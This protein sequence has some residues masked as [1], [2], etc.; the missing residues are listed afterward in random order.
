M[1]PRSTRRHV[2]VIRSYSVIVPSLQINSQ[3]TSHR[4]VIPVPSLFRHCKYTQHTGHCQKFILRHRYTHTS[5]SGHTGSVIVSSLQIYTT[6]RSL[7]KVHTPSSV[8]TH[9][10]RSYRLRHCFVTANIDNTHV[11]VKSLY[12]VISMS[13][14]YTATHT[15]SSGRTGSVGLSIAAKIGQH[16]PHS[17]VIV[18]SLQI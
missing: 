7:S 9:I 11:T 8:H 3:H 10:V 5:S 16:M 4:Q 14:H 18:S 17:Q 2:I 1:C 6:H 15:S 13:M 12:S